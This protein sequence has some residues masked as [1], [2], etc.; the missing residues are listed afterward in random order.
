M[1][2]VS[3]ELN[4]QDFLSRYH[5]TQLREAL[6]S[7]TSPAISISSEE[8]CQIV[9]TALKR[10]DY[11]KKHKGKRQGGEREKER[12]GTSLKKKLLQRVEGTRKSRRQQ[13]LSAE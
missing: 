5:E 1:D 6:A 11:N 10:H 7:V 12:D 3:L 13:G 8:L 2:G 4:L 9:E